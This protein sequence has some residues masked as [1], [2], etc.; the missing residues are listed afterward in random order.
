MHLIGPRYNWLFSLQLLGQSPRS[1][2]YYV[3]TET[4]F[5]MRAWV[6]ICIGYHC[7]K[8]HAL[9]LKH[10]LLTYVI[11]TLPLPNIYVKY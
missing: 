4:T 8:L 3:D 7:S 1:K 5:Q 6:P 11:L 2:L 9:I 10:T